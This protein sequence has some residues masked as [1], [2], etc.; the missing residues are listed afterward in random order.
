LKVCNFNSDYPL[1]KA[2]AYFSGYKWCSEHLK[3]KRGDSENLELIE[4]NSII[5]RLLKLN[6]N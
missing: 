3:S 6:F 2:D 5:E 4:K 1:R